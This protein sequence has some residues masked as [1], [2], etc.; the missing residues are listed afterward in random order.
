MGAGKGRAGG[1]RAEARARGARGCGDAP[2]TIGPSSGPRPAS[3]TPS[4]QGAPEAQD[5]GTAL[6]TM[7]GMVALG[8]L[9][10]A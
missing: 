10:L 6:S 1:A 5:T 2:S 7:T 8:E 9:L 4:T 3:S